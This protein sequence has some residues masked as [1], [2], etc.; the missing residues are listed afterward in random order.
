MCDVQ[1]KNRL[2]LF[3]FLADFTVRQ[4][5]MLMQRTGCHHKSVKNQEGSILCAL[6]APHLASVYSK[7]LKTGSSTSVDLCAMYS[8]NVLSF[9]N[10]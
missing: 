7:E 4:G 8:Q 5:T 10:S 3:Y 6:P 2:W 1:L 9:Q